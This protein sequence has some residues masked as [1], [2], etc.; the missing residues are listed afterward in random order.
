MNNTP[1]MNQLF[2]HYLPMITPS[3]KNEKSQ[4]T[5]NNSE[6]DKQTKANAIIIKQTF[7]VGC[8]RGLQKFK[9]SNRDEN[10]KL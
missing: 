6:K 1:N 7:Q 5:E 10:L 9:N 8:K 2:T 3:K 4:K